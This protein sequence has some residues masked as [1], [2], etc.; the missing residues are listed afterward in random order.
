MAQVLK[1][2][3]LLEE[4]EQI[5]KKSRMKAQL[6]A[7]SSKYYATIPHDVGKERLS[8]IETTSKIEQERKFLL[9]EF[10]LPVLS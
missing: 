7:L 5:V 6:W 8:N 1:G 4:L 3:D 2:Y 9:T 10:V